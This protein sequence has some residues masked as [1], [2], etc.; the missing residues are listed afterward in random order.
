MS[1]P[2]PFRLP[3]AGGRAVDG[4]VD[5]PNASGRRPTVVVVHGFKGFM[6]WGF[7][8]PL[9][10]LLRER[11]FTVVRF[12]VSGSGMEPGEDRATDLEGF[13]ANTFSR[14][15][16]DVDAV[17]RAVTT[18]KLPG[19]ERM[20]PE[21]LGLLGHSRG[22]GAAVLT[23]AAD[24]W[25]DRLHALVTWAALAT[26][27]RYDAEQKACWRRDGYLPVMNSRTDQE[28]RLGLGLLED[29]ENCREELDV[30][31][32]AGRV[33]VPWLIVHGTEDESV[34]VEDG[35]RL[36]AAA[37][38]GAEGRSGTVELLEIEGA[39]HTFGARHPFRG[40]T[41][42]LIEAMNATQTWL[43]RYLCD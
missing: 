8:P 21:R 22:G 30:V 40:P 18:G 12:N 17:L 24:S 29:L 3:T 25:R 31:A 16:E 15:L 32:A 1:Q 2:L 10:E 13:T 11:G 34:S 26:Y 33:C 36:H 20:D 6:E 23:A 19:G 9:A 37:R 14:E 39:G 35:R 43:R 27:D 28:M 7:F 41:P 4:L 5:V 42:D 38:A